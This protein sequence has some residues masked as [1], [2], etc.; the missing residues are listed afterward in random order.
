MQCNQ[1]VKNQSLWT[2]DSRMIIG[3]ITADISRMPVDSFFNVIDLPSCDL[4]PIDTH[5]LWISWRTR[6][7][8]CRSTHQPTLHRWHNPWES[9]DPSTKIITWLL[10]CLID[11]QLVDRPKKNN[12]NLWKLWQ[13]VDRQSPFPPIFKDHLPSGDG[14]LGVICP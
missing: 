5:M 4:R 3:R 14:R 7:T 1:Y 12:K 9:A 6:T 8:N 13:N 2:S 11:K 10:G